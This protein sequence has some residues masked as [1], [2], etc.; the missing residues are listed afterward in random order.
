MKSAGEIMQRLDQLEQKLQRVV[1]DEE[2]ERQKPYRQKILSSLIF[3]HRESSALKAA[4][5]ELEWVLAEQDENS[6]FQE[7]I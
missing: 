2:A 4:I 3:L 5:S 1:S 7:N 6:K